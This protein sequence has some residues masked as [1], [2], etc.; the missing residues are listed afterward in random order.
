MFY[1]YYNSIKFIPIIIFIIICLLFSIGII[2]KQLFDS[3]NIIDNKKFQDNLKI[4]KILIWTNYSIITLLFLYSLIVSLYLFRS[5]FRGVY[6]IT[7]RRRPLLYTNV[8][9]TFLIL[10]FTGLTYYINKG[11]D[12]INI[13]NAKEELKKIYII[14]PLFSIISILLLFYNFTKIQLLL[15]NFNYDI[16][17]G[18]NIDYIPSITRK[19][20]PSRVNPLDDEDIPIY[21]RDRS[22]R[23]S[24]PFIDEEQGNFQDE[25]QYL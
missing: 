20:S 12:N 14:V 3:V 10:I 19:R 21:F 7:S 6:N 18:I 24:P 4:Q 16:I 17:H 9:L 2:N 15:S 5:R 11:L 1:F 23:Y 22:P 13:M 8:I 25:F